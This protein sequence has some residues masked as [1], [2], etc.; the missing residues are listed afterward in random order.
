MKEYKPDRYAYFDVPSQPKPESG[1]ICT[2]TKADKVKRARKSLKRHR[3]LKV[4]GT[5][6]TAR[7]SDPRYSKT[8]NKKFGSL[9][10]HDEIYNLC[11]RDKNNKIALV[12]SIPSTLA[13]RL[14]TEYDLK[15]TAADK[16]EDDSTFI[17]LPNVKPR[18]IV[19]YAND[20]ESKAQQSAKT[21]PPTSQ[22]QTRGS[23]II[24]E[25]MVEGLE[26]QVE[27]QATQLKVLRSKLA[28]REEKLKAEKAA[29]EALRQ[30]TIRRHQYIAEKLNL[31]FVKK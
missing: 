2:P 24:A 6:A 13:K 7:A 18:D 23:P 12:E 30:E 31:I 19:S 15:F 29:F 10:L 8:S 21:P 1:L 25:S 16:F 14:T 9:H 28:K 5:D 4:L 20:L 17:P 11:K 26:K 3:F 27:M 22:T